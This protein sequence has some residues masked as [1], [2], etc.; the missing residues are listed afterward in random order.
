M[1]YDKAEK[2]FSEIVEYICK[3]L[4]QYVFIIFRKPDIA[5]AFGSTMV[6]ALSRLAVI[7]LLN[8]ET[9]CVGFGL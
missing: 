9:G 8:S 1:K 6:I 5:E 3:A 7:M 4:M 2:G